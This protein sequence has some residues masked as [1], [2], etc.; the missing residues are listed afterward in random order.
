MCLTSGNIFQVEADEA[1][2]LLALKEQLKRGKKYMALGVTN[3]MDLVK[4]SDMFFDRTLLMKE[5]L[6]DPSN[7]TVITLPPKWCKTVNMKMIES[8]LEIQV[9]RE[10]KR[11]EPLNET[12]NYRLFKNGEIVLDNGK[13]EK[14]TTP[15]L[16]S[17][18]ENVMEKYQGKYPVIYANFGGIRGY[19]LQQII[20]QTKE[21]IARCFERYNYMRRAL[22]NIVENKNSSAEEKKKAQEDVDMFKKLIGQRAS[23]E[24]AEKSLFFLSRILHEHFHQKVFVFVDEYDAPLNNTLLDD[25]YMR[26][27]EDLFIEFYQN[28]MSHTFR[29]NSHLHKGFLT[30]VLQMTKG[31]LFPF[32]NNATEHNVLE[33]KFYEFYNLDEKQAELLF[34]AVKAMRQ[35]RY[36]WNTWYLGY[37]VKKSS[38]SPH[39]DQWELLHAL[40]HI[41]LPPPGTGLL[42]KFFGVDSFREA[43]CC[44]VSGINLPHVN[45]T[46]V[47]FD[48]VNFQFLLQA[49]NEKLFGMFTYSAMKYLYSTGFLTSCDYVAPNDTRIFLKFANEKVNT[50]VKNELITYLEKQVRIFPQSFAR[51]FSSFKKE[52]IEFMGNSAKDAK[53]LEGHLQTY[54]AGIF[55]PRG[56]LRDFHEELIRAAVD[57]VILYFDDFRRILSFSTYIPL[58]DEEGGAIIDITWKAKSSVKALE[59]AR[60]G[61]HLFQTIKTLKRIK[62]IGINVVSDP[63][64]NVTVSIVGETKKF[65]ELLNENITTVKAIRN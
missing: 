65:E 52:F 57:Y 55:G 64:Q 63:E 34:D 13:V 53:R 42:R 59:R 61:K 15:L 4:D 24:E 41:P 56:E 2:T 28:I 48:K 12:R 8:F 39:Y 32:L 35:V 40:H 47:Y 54:L 6:E 3:F 60:G 51:Y 23:K 1:K 18:H 17:T 25:N 49:N 45:F 37:K 14:L 11:L 58:Y 9:D 7:V 50:F 26:S 38:K 29:N 33:N 62:F 44:L 16:I 27:H 46:N 36:T 10:G 30:G 22:D 43:I 31:T 19:N 21:K 5:F 20:V